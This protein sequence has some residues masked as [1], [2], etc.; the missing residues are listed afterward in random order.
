[1]GD[2]FD[3]DDVYFDDDELIGRSARSSL[4]PGL[5]V[6][7]PGGLLGQD[8]RGLFSMGVFAAGAPGRTAPP[9]T[10]PAQLC[11]Y[12]REDLSA[13]RPPRH[14]LWHARDDTG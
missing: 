13:S 5:V 8:F 11:R 9:V 1:M 12:W 6:H 4:G 7:E 3:D 10:P 14:G 2:F